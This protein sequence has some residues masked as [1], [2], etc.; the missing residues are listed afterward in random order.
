MQRQSW[1]VSVASGR[2]KKCRFAVPQS[3]F[4]RHQPKYII[5]DDLDD[6]AK[7]L[8]SLTTAEAERE[9][10]KSASGKKY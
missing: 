3:K 2:E 1:D 7:L 10:P 5:A 8:V 4:G 9:D 6:P